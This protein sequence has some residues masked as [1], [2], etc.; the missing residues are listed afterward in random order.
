MINDGLWDV[1][2]NYHMGMTGERIAEKYHVSREMADE[3]ACASQMKA[4]AAQKEGR[5]VDEIVAVQDR[6]GVGRGIAFE[7]DECIRG[8]TTVEQLA[9]LKPAFK[10]GGVLHR[11]ELVPAQRRCVGPRGRVG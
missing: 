2:N 3:F 7:Q 8:D 10:P 1:Y 9:K 4:A 11:G 5:F 6:R